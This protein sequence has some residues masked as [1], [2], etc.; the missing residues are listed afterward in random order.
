MTGWSLIK[1]LITQKNRKFKFTLSQLKRIKKRIY[2][3]FKTQKI[4][5]YTVIVLTLLKAKMCGSPQYHLKISCHQVSSDWSVTRGFLGFSVRDNFITGEK[6]SFYW[7]R[8]WNRRMTCS[9]KFHCVLP[10]QR[11]GHH[12][13][14]NFT[15]IDLYLFCRVNVW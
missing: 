11:L 8:K 3:K 1:W 12:Y 6:K 15:L 7:I 4:L 2:K 10:T 14:W 9:N 5:R 13:K